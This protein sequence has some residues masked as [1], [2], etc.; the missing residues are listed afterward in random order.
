MGI[1]VTGSI[2]RPRIFISTSI[3]V[4]E[5]AVSEKTLYHHFA[6]KAVGKAAG[7]HYR[8][9]STN[10]WLCVVADSEIKLLVLRCSP[11]PLASSFVLAFHHHLKR[12]PHIF[13][14]PTLLDQSLL[15]I[16]HRQ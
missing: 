1:F 15:F 8:H 9:I 12:R 7:H 2:R 14:I 6:Q 5:N 11:N 3:A 4:S 13:L 16:E 10:I